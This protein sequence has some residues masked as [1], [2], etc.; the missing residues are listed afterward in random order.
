M[1]Q[2][3]Y[4]IPGGNQTFVRFSGTAGGDVA[5]TSGTGRVN[6]IVP[7]TTALSGQAVLLYDSAVARSG[8]PAAASGH[9]I[10]GG[11]PASPPT[12]A[13]GTFAAALPIVLNVP[14]FSGLC[15]TGASGQ[16]GFTVV[17]SNEKP[18]V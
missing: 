6:M 4:S 3:T 15:V 18:Q 5:I 9:V 13:S 17:F 10:L 14:F 16:V 1:P 12:G 8:G 7:H 11:I 2:P